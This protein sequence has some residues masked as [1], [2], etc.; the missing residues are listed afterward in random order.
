MGK[1]ISSVGSTP[2]VRPEKFQFFEKW[3]KIVI[4]ITELLISVK[5]P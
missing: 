2:V 3:Q 1:N 5:N 4:S